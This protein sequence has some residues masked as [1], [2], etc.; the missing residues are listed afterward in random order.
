MTT[1]ID[2]RRSLGRRVLL[3]AWIS[4]LT[5]F[6]LIAIAIALFGDPHAEDPL[7][8]LAV[9]R[10]P[11]HGPP[12]HMQQRQPTGAQPGQEPAVPPALMPPT[13]TKPVY[14]G[15]NLLADPALVEASPSGPLP[16]V[17]EDGRA[18]M[19]V[20]SGAIDGPAG[21]PRIAIVI[22]GAGI[23]A[24]Q[25]ASALAALPSQVTLAFA[26]YATDVQRWVGEARREGHEVLVQVPMEAYETPGS[27]PGPH[28]LRV[29]QGEQNNIARLTWA[30]SRFTGYTGVMNLAGSRFLADDESLTP[31]LAYVAKRGLLF[32]DDGAARHS[33]A[34]EIARRTG[35]AFAQSGMRIDSIAS[36]VEIDNK[37][38]TLEGEA[39]AHGIAIG[40]GYVSSLTVT[41][42]ANW[43]SGLRKR[44]F[45][46]VPASAIVSKTGAR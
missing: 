14:A 22:S 33:L 38:A 13:I 4:V 1:E 36:A 23:S 6:A 24:K 17:A 30:L 12:S 15:N 25:T 9:E 32:F 34:A 40:S 31:M 5:F 7:I 29:D 21:I 20:Y 39:K 41:R 8:R 16:R 26:P 42:V 19:L 45:V 18:P 28:T 10:A 35:V 43:A 44:G 46:I 3:V 2:D 37:L 27:D 11:E